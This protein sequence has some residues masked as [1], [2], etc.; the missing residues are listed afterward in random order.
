MT[1]SENNDEHRVEFTGGMDF[2]MIAIDATWRRPCVMM[3]ISAQGAKLV[4][5]GSVEGLDISEFFLVLSGTGL[6]FRRCEL[7]WSNGGQVGVRFLDSQDIQDN[8]PRANQ[9]NVLA[10]M[11][12]EGELDH[13]ADGER[14]G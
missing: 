5:M 13:G 12:V 10:S 1:K 6:A 8:K 3:E 7:A 11:L 4:I 2:H 14:R 9:T